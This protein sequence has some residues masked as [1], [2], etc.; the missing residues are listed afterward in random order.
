MSV[1]AALPDLLEDFRV[2]R[3]GGTVVD[4]DSGEDL[5]EV[6]LADRHPYDPLV[7]LFRVFLSDPAQLHLQ[8]GEDG[9]QHV[10]LKGRVGR[11]VTGAVTG[12]DIDDCH[13]LTMA[14][15]G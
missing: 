11:E 6:L 15:R 1:P 10:G 12:V 7:T 2:D 13:G 4:V 3:L 8:S 14:F 9:D 5:L